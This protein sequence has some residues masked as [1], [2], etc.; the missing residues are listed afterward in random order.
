MRNNHQRKLFLPLWLVLICVNF[1]CLFEVNA[2]SVKYT[3]NLPSSMTPGETFS[4]E[5]NIN[6][7]SLSSFAKF[8]MD[9]PAGFTAN[10]VEVKGGSWT[11]DQQRAKI[12]WVSFPSEQNF[13]V[14][15]KI[16]APKN[17]SSSS[18]ITSKL[19]YLE[20]NVKQETEVP[21]HTI[22]FNGEGSVKVEDKS[23]K[24]EKKVSV[25]DSKSGF[26]T[27]AKN[28]TPQSLNTDNQ[29]KSGGTKKEDK[30]DKKAEDTKKSDN[31][32]IV[33]ANSKTV[34]RL[35]IGAFASKPDA[36]K[37]KQYKDFWYY[38]ENGLYKVTIG[39]FSSLADA[40]TFKTEMKNKGT[41]GFVVSFENN[42]HVKI[43]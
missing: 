5:V 25:T 31:T 38:E 18:T 20:N 16:T 8:Q 7:G 29:V 13:V 14:K 24:E 41:E 11:Y 27:T 32:E 19:F 40:E 6:K 43:H 23:N 10:P 28:S 42:V 2:Q 22:N 33:H 3:H 26:D 17:T 9:L 30:K 21:A 4:V 35:Q 1:L 39:K 37:F 12:V 36:S 15:F 34:Y